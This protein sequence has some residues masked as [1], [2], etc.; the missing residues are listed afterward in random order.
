MS[1]FYE[2]RFFPNTVL[3]IRECKCHRRIPTDELR[4]ECGKA[5]DLD[6]SSYVIVT[7]HHQAAA[8]QRGA[9]GLRLKIKQLG[10]DKPE[11]EKYIKGQRD[12]VAD[13]GENLREADKDADFRR[14]M[15]EGA[16]RAKAKEERRQ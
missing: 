5:F 14:G 4:K 15:E 3:A 1:R 16:T 12:L 2:L 11:R 6:V 9:A 13:L 7:Y 8:V 10:L